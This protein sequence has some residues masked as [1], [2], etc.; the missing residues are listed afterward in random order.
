L[1]LL[2]LFL[3]LQV[4]L[5]ATIDSVGLSEAVTYAENKNNTEIGM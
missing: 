5:Y 1:F 4:L 2:K 3:N